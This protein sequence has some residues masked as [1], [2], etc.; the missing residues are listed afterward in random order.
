MTRKI[1][2]T[3]L[4]SKIARRIFFLFISCAIFPI[5]I[6][7][8]LTFGT[9]SSALNQLARKELRQT[10]KSTALD[11]YNNLLIIESKINSISLNAEIEDIRTSINLKHPKEF[12]KDVTFFKEHKTISQISGEVSLLP[13]LTDGALDHINSGEILIFTQDSKIFMTRKMKPGLIIAEI[14]K[15]YL[16]G[17]EPQFYVSDFN[18]TILTD[19]SPPFHIN[20]KKQVISG[21]FEYSDKEETYIGSFWSIFL[22]SR[23]F[24]P[25]W[26]IIM[27]KSRSDILQ[28]M[29]T[30]KN[31]FI[32]LSVLSFLIV[33][34][35]SIIQIRRSLVPIEILQEGTRKIASGDFRPN[36]I[37]KSGDEFEELGE[38]FNQMSKELEEMN[39]ILIQ[40]AKMKTIGQMSSAIVHE[41]NQPLTA[42]KGY[43]ELI[44]NFD[45][46]PGSSKKYF[47]IVCKS[48]DR[49]SEI[50]GKFK[51]FSR[52]SI[53]DP[54]SNISLNDSLKTL[55]EVL[56]HQFV[57]KEVE[58]SLDLEEGLPL[59]MGNDNNL[60]QVFMNLIVN[61]L[62]AIEDE[63]ACKNDPKK[64]VI[65]VNTH[66]NN[67]HV[68]ATV[69]D[70][71]PGI[72][73]EVRKKIFEPFFTTKSAGK[74]TGLGLAVIKS[75]IQHHKGKI[76]IESKDGMGTCFILTFP[77]TPKQ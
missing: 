58:F 50:A 68:I 12:F 66:S 47:Q 77:T 43:L 30:F 63:N 60:Q 22:R 48:V 32:L 65:K 28:P 42:I 11:I 2:T 52:G 19:N 16:W 4:K 69:E 55:H 34:L 59:I 38:S 51:R 75:I 13:E 31:I 54:L 29:L 41:I 40:T 8:S 17:K 74:G 24:T 35:L 36:I 72:P 53:D 62:D 1:D 18:N 23:F 27:S 49:L 15:D 14:K 64:P 6:L 5:A 39:S 33:L 3:F 71:G 57:K 25:Y 61:A 73:L 44:L 7:A 76:E 20:E 10:C 21:H 46:L 45:D 56:E 70:N 37:I 26:T 9:I 67:D